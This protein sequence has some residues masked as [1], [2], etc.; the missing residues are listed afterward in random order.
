[1]PKEYRLYGPPGSGKSTEL[2]RIYMQ[3]AAKGMDPAKICVVTFTRTAA[4]EIRARV[5][6]KL[7]IDGSQTMLRRRLPLVGTIHSIAMKL[8]GVTRQQIVSDKQLVQFCDDANA[9]VPK[10]L[11]NMAND[12]VQDEPDMLYLELPTN[13]DEVEIM[14]FAVSA[15]AHRMIPIDDALG[16]IPSELLLR[17]GP[18]R[19]LTLARKYRI[20]K[21]EHSLLDFDDLLIEGLKAQLP[22]HALLADEVQDNSPLLWAALDAWSRTTKIYVMAGDPYQALYIFNGAQPDLF[23]NHSGALKTVGDSHRFGPKTTSFARQILVEAY[24]REAAEMLAT[25][26]G[27][28][29]RERDGDTL[30]LTRT[31]SQLAIIEAQLRDDG[32][33]YRKYRG[34]APL[35][36]Q[37]GD[38]WRTL[39]RLE[40]GDAVQVEELHSVAKQAFN[41]P[42]GKKTAAL[43]QRGYRIDLDQAERILGIHTEHVDVAYAA[44]FRRVDVWRTPTTI[45]GTIH[46]AKG[47]EADHVVL[48]RSWAILPGK[49]LANN[50]LPEACVAYV[51]A[52]RHRKSLNIV[53]W[54]PGIPYPFPGSQITED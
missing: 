37:A 12:Y 2:T 39:R 43:R 5:G 25:W 44:Y 34:K 33:P 54:A 22:A 10:R 27:V 13:V 29:G 7:G 20:W 42:Y 45:I 26:K 40:R 4:E 46:S 11:K 35:Q 21:D 48:L 19:I 38:A 47:R 24:G 41:L 14:R 17:V 51:G 52:T 36:S 3:L 1:M 23:M 53:D 32:T 8:L 50:P 16:L 31:N 28:G 9:S 49:A 30:Y 15:A 18:D 6:A